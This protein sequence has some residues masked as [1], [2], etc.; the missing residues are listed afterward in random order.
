MSDLTPHKIV[1]QLI[2]TRHNEDGDII[3]EEIMGEVAIY[4]AN[5]G[6]VEELVDLAISTAKDNE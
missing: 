4:R 3:A 5:F 1:G 6:K 2:G